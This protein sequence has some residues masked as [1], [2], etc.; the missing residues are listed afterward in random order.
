MSNRL[1]DIQKQSL[2]DMARRVIECAV[3]GE[4]VGEFESEDPLFNEPLGCFV[5]LHNQGQLRGCIG[6][7]QPSTSLI[8]TV[9]EMAIATTQDSRFRNH[10]VTPQ[11]LTQIDVEIS[12]LSP[13]EETEDPLSLIRGEHGIYIRAGATSGCF[14]PQVATDTGWSKEEFLSHC[15]SDKA[16]LPADAWK[17]PQ[18]E[19]FL[20]TADVFSEKKL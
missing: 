10:P 5:T 8:R 2:L 4:P 3:R 7:F 19:V 20:F 16:G 15:C 9:R 12:V 13:L 1:S 17:D 11:E 18:T 14:L 6:H